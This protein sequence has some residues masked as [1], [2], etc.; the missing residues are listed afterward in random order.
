MPEEDGGDRGKGDELGIKNR[1]L[2]PMRPAGPHPPEAQDHHRSVR[3]HV[4]QTWPKTAMRTGQPA[5]R[6]RKLAKPTSNSFPGM[7]THVI[8]RLF[9]EPLV[10]PHFVV[11]PCFQLGLLL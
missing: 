6:G 10:Y 2:V 3:Q 7:A 4:G 11:K 1:V 8:Q 5:E 9:P